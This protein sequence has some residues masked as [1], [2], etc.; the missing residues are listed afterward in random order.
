MFLICRPLLLISIV[1]PRSPN[2]PPV[3]QPDIILLLIP[4]WPLYLKREKTQDIKL[5]NYRALITVSRRHSVP[6]NIAPTS[7]KF[8]AYDRPL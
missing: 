3:I 2:T 5:V 1:L 6:E 7:A 4:P 8:L